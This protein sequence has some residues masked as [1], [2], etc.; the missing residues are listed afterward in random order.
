MSYYCQFKFGN[1]T[2]GFPENHEVHRHTSMCDPSQKWCGR[3]SPL[4]CHAFKA[5]NKPKVI[6]NPFLGCG[7][8]KTP[9]FVKELPKPKWDNA[10]L[11]REIFEV[12]QYISRSIMSA[13][14][15]NQANRCLQA[16]KEVRRLRRE[17]TALFPRQYLASSFY[18]KLQAIL[19]GGE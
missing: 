13:A 18:D 17:I 7:A 5:V 4:S 8:V 19:D 2:C 9:V 10:D 14:H 6:P 16:L 1:D 12:Q 15:W 11:D 3:H